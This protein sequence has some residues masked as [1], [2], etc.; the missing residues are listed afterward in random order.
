MALIH[1]QPVREIDSLQDEMNRLFGRFFE[2]PQD[3]AGN[4]QA[5]RWLP[6]MDLVETTDHFV[7]RADLP[8]VA[9]DDV[10][11]ELEDSVLSIS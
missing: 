7:L 3:S 9:E 2:H 4:G 11:I 5:R 10:K 1:W 8:G 6:A